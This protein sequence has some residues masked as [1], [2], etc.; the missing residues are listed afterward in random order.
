MKQRDISPTMDLALSTVQT[1]LA[2]AD[3]RID[4]ALRANPHDEAAA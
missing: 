4:I 3:Q 2:R 1:M